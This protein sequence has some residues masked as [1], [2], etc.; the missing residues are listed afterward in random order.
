MTTRRDTP[1]ISLPPQ[2]AAKHWYGTYCFYPI[3]RN[4][5]SPG[6]SGN[7]RMEW[8]VQRTEHPDSFQ[9]STLLLPK[10]RPC[11]IRLE[12]LQRH[13]SIS[14]R[15]DF[16][17][18]WRQSPRTMWAPIL[19]SDQ[20]ILN[21]HLPMDLTGTTHQLLLLVHMCSLK[22][23][24]PWTWTRSREERYGPRLNKVQALSYFVCRE[25][26]SVLT[27]LRRPGECE[28]IWIVS[29]R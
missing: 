23:F 24:T 9:I 27:L 7:V 16:S 26:N 18:A 21:M 8:E 25:L 6:S 4:R 29:W 5:W 12:L 11:G 13:T 20:S 28:R 19:F 14:R 10:F 2:V 15:T 1:S 17:C 3:P 22:R